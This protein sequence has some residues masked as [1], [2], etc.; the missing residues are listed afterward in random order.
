MSDKKLAS[1]IAEGLRHDPQSIAIQL[2]ERGWVSI[3]D[4]YTGLDLTQPFELTREDV[5]DAV[6]SFSYG[7]FEYN[8]DEDRVC[9]KSGHTTHQVSYEPASN[10]PKF[11]YWVIPER[12][13]YN[14]LQIG[15]SSEHVKYTRLY[16]DFEDLEESTRI[17]QPV[18]F[19]IN[20]E[21]SAASFFYR[22]SKW[23]TENVNP[24]DLETSWS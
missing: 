7:R 6:T 23:W 22:D 18:F 2:D 10:P 16:D 3:E 15:I 12:D 1:I 8:E 24:S 17:S 20:T 5:I 9:A 13:Q 11:L 4:L 21:T 14:A 19:R